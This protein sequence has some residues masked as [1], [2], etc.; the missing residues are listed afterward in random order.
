[1]RPSN[2]QEMAFKLKSGDRPFAL[3]KIGDVTD[4]M[5][6][7]LGEYEIQEGFKDETYFERIN[8]DDSDINIL[9]GSRSFYEGWDSNRP[10]VILYINIGVGEDARK[11]IL[12]SVGRA[13]R[14]EPIKY[15]R[16]RLMQ[17]HQSGEI[18]SGLFHTLKGKVAPME[19]VVII[20]TNRIALTKV[21][22][23]LRIES[24]I[25]YSA[26]LALQKNED[27]IGG[28]VMLVPVYRDGSRKERLTCNRSMQPMKI[29]IPLRL[30][31]TT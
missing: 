25:A 14:I 20:G 11:F 4:W 23:E 24:D 30:M 31:S 29:V 15:Q 19:S 2:R 5:K 16:K 17:L 9:M 7:E 6:G 18:D 27:A 8:S 1:M 28:H 13:V 3:I 10:N 22:D 21:M 26:E 12:Q